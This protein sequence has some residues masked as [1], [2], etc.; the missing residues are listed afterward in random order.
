MIRSPRREARGAVL[1]ETEIPGVDAKQAAQVLEQGAGVAQDYRAV[2]S[3]RFR[4]NEQSAVIDE[5][6]PGQIHD[7]RLVSRSGGDHAPEIGS[8]KAVE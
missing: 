8:G 5:L 4:E 6:A 1:L 3:G 2:A 7:Q